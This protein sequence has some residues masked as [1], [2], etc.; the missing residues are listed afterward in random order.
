MPTARQD[1]QTEGADAS[2]L[3]IVPLRRHP[4][5]SRRPARG[6]DIVPPTIPP[7]ISQHETAP[8][9]P[10]AA[11]HRQHLDRHIDRSPD[12]ELCPTREPS[13]QRGILLPQRSAGLGVHLDRQPPDRLCHLLPADA[14]HLEAPDPLAPKVCIVWDIWSWLLVRIYYLT[15]RHVAAS[16]PIHTQLPS[17]SSTHTHTH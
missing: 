7:N 13:A 4:Q 2:F 5:L 11:H 1:L 17:S 9:L 10:M 14:L 3:C 8:H 12:H 15:P 6:Q 16:S